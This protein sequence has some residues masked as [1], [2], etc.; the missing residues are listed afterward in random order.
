MDDVLTQIYPFLSIGFGWTNPKKAVFRA[1]GP[2]SDYAALEFEVLPKFL[3][4]KVIK[5]KYGTFNFGH[6]R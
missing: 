2:D 1:S 5:K 6:E 4:N 3:P